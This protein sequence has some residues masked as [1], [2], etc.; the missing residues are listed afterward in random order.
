MLPTL[1]RRTVAALLVLCL[2]CGLALADPVAPEAPRPINAATLRQ[3]ALVID[4]NLDAMRY[5]EDHLRNEAPHRLA[6]VG[7]DPDATQA[8]IEQKLGELR[9][10]A[11][12]VEKTP[13]LRLSTQGQVYTTEDGKLAISVPAAFGTLG[14]EAP[15]L[16]SPRATPGSYTVLIANTDLLTRWRID[17]AQATR[18][19]KRIEVLG[20]QNGFVDVDL[21]LHRVTQNWIFHASIAEAKWYAD[22]T[23]SRLIGEVRE[24]RNGER[25]AR[26]G[27][28]SEGVSL[29][30]V[31]EHSF[32]MAE[33][34][35]LEIPLYGAGMLTDCKEQKRELKHRVVVCGRKGDHL[36][37]FTG[38]TRIRIVGG[39]IVE[40][41]V[42]GNGRKA[43]DL[44]I[45]QLWRFINERLHN[46]EVAQLKDAMRWEQS[47]GTL[48]FHPERLRS[49]DKKNPVMWAKATSYLDFTD[50]HPDNRFVP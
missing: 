7:H 46:R 15:W 9:E 8:L 10:A 22:S 39:R 33:E 45:E 14:F 26:Q 21:R 24:S 29:E 25:L 35:I 4:P 40:I 30:K 2:W 11:R 13:T 28:L 27:W 12:W 16:G 17:P 19:K 36:G 41:A 20:A 43:T 31:P 37:E 18:L 38:E 44:Q 47:R 3:V 49:G 32:E 23:R 42:Y 6:S 34:R 1:A 48:G 50:A 5:A